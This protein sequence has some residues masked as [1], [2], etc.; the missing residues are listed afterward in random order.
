MKNLIIFLFLA[1]S[2]CT[3]V[4]EK[5][6]YEKIDSQTKQLLESYPLEKRVFI[7]TELKSS[8]S[9]YVDFNYALQKY[10][11][12]IRQ[13]PSAESSGPSAG[14]IAVGVGAGVIGAKVLGKAL[15]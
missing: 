13:R 1:L 15:K 6:A 2:S 14:E 5:T 8:T 10:Y 11:E 12:A 7:E 4:P 9:S 3:K